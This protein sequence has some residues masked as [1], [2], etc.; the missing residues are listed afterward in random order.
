MVVHDLMCDKDFFKENLHYPPASE[1]SRGVYD[2]NY[3]MKDLLMKEYFV[4]GF[5]TLGKTF[6]FNVKRAP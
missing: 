5:Y 2:F 3:L 6:V 4:K 1:A